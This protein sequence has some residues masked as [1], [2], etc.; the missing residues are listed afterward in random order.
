MIDE[1]RLVAQLAI[2]LVFLLSASAKL[3]NPAGFAR[4]VVEYQV[5]PESLA[6][7][8][9]LLL[10][11]LEVF[12][13]VSHLSGWMLAFAVPA[14]LGALVAFAAAVAINL[15]RGRA[16]PCYC[17]GGEGG[18]TISARALARLLLLLACELFVLTDPALFG[19]S[20]LVYPGRLASFSEL[21]LALFWATFLLVAA[22]WV[23]S[24][25]DVIE[26]LRPGA[27]EVR[28]GS[29]PAGR[30]ADESS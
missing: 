14:G 28:A 6:Y 11:P 30:P 3:L 17:F 12:L 27:R 19:R 8:A 5:L 1:A 25:T 2:G 21:G 7:I 13:A 9:G 22:L 20:Q 29:N 4:G 26:L 18:E 24:V 23:L 10:I 16:L 15:R